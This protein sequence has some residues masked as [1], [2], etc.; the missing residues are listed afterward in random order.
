MSIPSNN[1]ASG[2]DG[3]AVGGDK[4]GMLAMSVDI[5]KSGGVTAGGGG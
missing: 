1:G 2:E 4:N 5:G 3:S